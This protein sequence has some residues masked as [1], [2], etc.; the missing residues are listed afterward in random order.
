MN[1]ERE[2]II[3]GLNYQLQR[4]VA[5]EVRHLERT[6]KNPP[7]D[8]NISMRNLEHTMKRAFEIRRLRIRIYK[9]RTQ[10]IPKFPSGACSNDNGLASVGQQGPEIITC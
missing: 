3:R 5:K 6:L 8:I 9:I 1:K 7:K 4:L 2:H 10:P